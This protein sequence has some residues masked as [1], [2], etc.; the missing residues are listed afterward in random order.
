MLAAAPSA[1]LQCP[2]CKRVHGVR[3]GDRPTAGAAITHRLLPTALPGHPACGTIQVTFQFKAGVQGPEHPHPGRPYHPVG[4]PRSAFLPDSPAGERALHGLYLAWQQRLIFTV[5]QSIT[6]GREDSVTWND[7][8]LK[9]QDPD[10]SY[11]DP[12][13]LANLAQEL[14][15]FGITEAE[16]GSHLAAHPDLR[17]RGRL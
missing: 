7:I 10:H 6:T 5:G 12:H 3:T 17:T 2:T 4:F 15:G 13:H 8:H 16:V 11:P 9:T 14:A 1:F